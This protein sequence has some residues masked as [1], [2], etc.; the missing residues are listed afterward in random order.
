MTIQTNPR[1]EEILPLMH[2]VSLL[3]E[4]FTEYWP[5]YV[6]LAIFVAATFFR[7][8]RGRGMP[9]DLEPNQDWLSPVICCWVFQ[10]VVSWLFGS[11]YGPLAYFAIDVLVALATLI[12]I[13]VTV[14]I[15]WA[16]ATKLGVPRIA[17]LGGLGMAAI[18]ITNALLIVSSLLIFYTKFQ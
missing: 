12:F 11:T 13:I 18:V 8:P 6:L 7:R 2:P 1:P 4:S 16:V 5:T 17:P 15:T 3:Q 10:A 14:T 9:N